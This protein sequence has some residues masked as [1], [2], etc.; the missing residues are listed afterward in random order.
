M[1]L[2]Q[3]IGDLVLGRGRPAVCVPVTGSDA[4]S[5]RSEA[6]AIP[7]GVADI[8]E[9]R[10]DFLDALDAR[11]L[12]TSVVRDAIVAVRDALPR[13][14]PLL[15]TFRSASEG[16]QRE[17]SPADLEAVV[18]QA[19]ATGAVDAVDVEQFSPSRDRLVDRVHAAG[20]PVVMSSHDFEGTPAQRE[21]V[22][23][24]V[25]QQELGADVVKLAC[26]PAT[27]ADVLTLLAATEEFTR[28]H[29]TK[30]AIAMAMGALGVVTRLAGETFGSVLTFGT[31][32]AASAPGQVDAVE[33][34][35]SLDLV[36]GTRD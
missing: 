35:R 7:P 17:L 18:E 27:P 36:H 5:L 30:P 21:L 14:V 11:P 12:D 19:V 2:T 22:G 9:V 34:R 4:E 31:V 16:G 23:R 1:T 20:L 3:A 10:I 32:G 29:A 15:L 33:L 25:A 26:M 24:L 6:A 8:V 28:E 13:G